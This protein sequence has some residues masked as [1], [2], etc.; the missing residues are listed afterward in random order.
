[1]IKEE[2]VHGFSIKD[3]E[4]LLP[5]YFRAYSTVYTRTEEIRV[6]SECNMNVLILRLSQRSATRTVH[7]VE[8]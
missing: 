8:T 1:M 5:C 7:M 4:D 6:I 3:A 2:A